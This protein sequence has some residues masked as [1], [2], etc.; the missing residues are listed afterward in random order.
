MPLVVPVVVLAV[1][2]PVFAPMVFGEN[3]TGASSV[4]PAVNDTGENGPLFTRAK[5]EPDNAIEST[6]VAVVAVNCAVSVEDWP[7]VVAEKSTLLPVSAGVKGP[8]PNPSKCPSSVP[9]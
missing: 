6:V 2:V 5:E 4:C 3:V 9:T 1:S 8:K 7:T